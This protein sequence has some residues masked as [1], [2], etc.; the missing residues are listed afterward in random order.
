M[1]LSLLTAKECMIPLCSSCVISGRNTRVREG[2]RL[3]E[4]KSECL[5]NSTC[6]GINFERNGREGDCSFIFNEEQHVNFEAN[7]NFE[8]WSKSTNCGNCNCYY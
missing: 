8:G 3:E 1:I 5:N 7:E 6:L 4:C 2:L